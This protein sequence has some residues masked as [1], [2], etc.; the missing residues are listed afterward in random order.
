VVAD[1]SRILAGPLATQLLSDAGARVIKIEEIGRGDETR[2]WG[3]PFVE[4]ESAYFLSLNR[5]KESLTLNL[6]SAA[7]RR[8]ARQL[9]AS[10]DIVVQNFLPAQQKAFGL[11]AAQVH[12]ANRRVVHCTIRGYDRDSVEADLPGYDLLAQAGGGLMAITGAADGDPSKVGVALSD[13]LT[14]HH[15]HGGILAA[16]F[17]RERTGRGVAVEVSILGSTIAS[18][19]NV[20]QS[21]LVTGREPQRFGNEHPSIVPY[22][23]FHA[24]DRLFVVAVATDRHYTLL[25]SEVLGDSALLEDARFATNALRVLNREAFVPLLEQHFR[26]EV[27]EVW[28]ERCRRTGIPAEKVQNFHEIFAGAGAPLVDE[29]THSSIGAMR[30]VGSPTRIDGE[31]ARAREAP[32]RLGQHTAAILRELGYDARAVRKLRKEGVV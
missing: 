15:A 6:K 22:Q 32:P 14:A 5:N 8:I 29:L 7:G 17:A 10:A 2:R 11:T 23:A 27:A 13:V 18:L 9:V 1:F 24:S 4:E 20:A 28:V 21:Y 30:V 31:R 3:P 26:R 16:L 25:C 12:R 19:V